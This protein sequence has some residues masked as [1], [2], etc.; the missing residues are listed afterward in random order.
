MSPTVGR[1]VH[2]YDFTLGKSANDGQGWGP[3]AAIVTRVR[4][5]YEG[6]DLVVFGLA[7]TA[8]EVRKVFEGDPD[9]TARYWT[10]PPREG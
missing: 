8:K 2:Y 4:S 9:N 6:I 10:W 1:I 5:H 3:Y 7:D